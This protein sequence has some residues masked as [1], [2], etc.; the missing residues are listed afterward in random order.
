VATEAKRQITEGWE[1][2]SIGFQTDAIW[3]GNV[4]PWLFEWTR[5]E[6]AP[7]CVA[8][9]SYP[10]QRHQMHVYQVVSCG[11]RTQ[12]AAGE[13]SNGVWGFFKPL[14]K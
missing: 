5:I 9:P 13:F 8:R 11:V 2:V 14:T 7:I 10:N 4:N 1:F 3:I 6:C 12:F